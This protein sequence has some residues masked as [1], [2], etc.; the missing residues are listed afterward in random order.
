MLKGNFNGKAEFSAAII[1]SSIQCHV[2]L[3][4]WC[5]VIINY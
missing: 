3:Q 5:S 1:N 2:I 4:S